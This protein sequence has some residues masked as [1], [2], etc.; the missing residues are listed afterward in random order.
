MPLDLLVLCLLHLCDTLCLLAL[1]L[2]AHVG[3]HTVATCQP[4]RL[5][6]LT[7]RLHLSSLC[8]T[9]FSFPPMIFYTFWELSLA[10]SIE[11]HRWNILSIHFYN[12][13]ITFFIFV[14]TYTFT[15]HLSP[16]VRAILQ[17]VTALYPL[18][19]SQKGRNSPYLSQTLYNAFVTF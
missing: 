8:L 7:S 9:H 14:I 11:Y 2:L 15:T 4:E 12:F 19:S 17:G 16:T 13:V 10:T 3:I 5:S 1:I 6:N 18:Y